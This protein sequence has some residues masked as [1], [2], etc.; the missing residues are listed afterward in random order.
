VFP[1]GKVV[2]G[3]AFPSSGAGSV[4]LIEGRLLD[5]QF[6]L[7]ELERLNANDPQLGGRL[8]LD[9][10][11]AFG[12][13]LGGST[14]AQL[15]L[16]DPRCK[17]GAG[18]DTWCYETNLLTQPL[19]VPWLSFRS[20]FG[21]DPDSAYG[22]P[23]GYPDDRLGLYREQVTNAYWVRL[24]STCHGD[25]VDQD[26]IIDSAS[27]KADW[28]LPLSGQFLPPTRV[29]QIVRAYLLSF[30]NK[31]L[32]GDDDH[33]LDGLS[34]AYPEVMQFLSKSSVSVGPAYPVA[35]LVQGS[36]GNFYGTTEYGG[37]SG[38]GTV[39]QVTPAGLLTTLVSFNGTN[40]SYP[41]AGLVQG[42]DGNLY[43]TTARG[44]A[45]GMGTVFEMTSAGVLRT[46]VSFNSTDGAVPLSPLVQA[47]DGNFYGTTEYG[48]T[49]RNN[50]T[51]FQ[52]TPAGA[53]TTLVSFNGSN[54]SYP[55]AG[56]VQGSDGN[57]YGTTSQGGDLSV[58]GGTGGGTVFKMTP[59]GLL[60]TLVVF[61][62]TGGMN[63][64]AGLVQ[65]TNGNFYGTT[66]YGGN[67]SANAGFG[68]GTVFRM[69]SAG[70]LTTLVSFNLANGYIPSAGLVQG[71]DG[72][73]YG[74]TDGGGAGGCGTVFKMT[75]A[76][77]LT[78]L[79]SFNGADGNSPQAP[80]VQGSDGNFY[81]TTTY[82][83]AGGFGTVFR[84]TP[85][86]VLTTLVSFGAH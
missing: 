73:F 9:K 47:S 66:A 5:E 4:A 40:G 30:F 13:C 12:W 65:G 69:T 64:T 16:R 70:A 51:V 35:V 38:K 25:Y 23:D 53:L 56:L 86:G 41:A 1:N 83:G 33:L 14:A 85:A 18:L 54:G 34:P 43:G 37:A 29:S 45:S 11:G 48:G 46:L 32:Q 3:T 59:A 72:N 82:G 84:V 74:T 42:S 10:I 76:G 15:C 77:V 24:G 57:L 62:G 49:N 7:D 63:S 58:N 21:P 20:G 22:L 19:S 2:Y 44:G 8:D 75:P 17:A 61:N 78:T 79:V 80:L 68:F 52:M 55:A 26:L 71:S 67:L 28:G 39:F 60:T 81:G 6:V 36:D 31:Y 50:G 27:L